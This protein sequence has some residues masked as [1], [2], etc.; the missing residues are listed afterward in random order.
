MPPAVAS[1]PPPAKI[2][3][4]NGTRQRARCA[5]G[6]QATS[7]S[8]FTRLGSP[9]ADTGASFGIGGN[10]SF[11]TSSSC[12][13]L[14]DRTL[15]ASLTAIRL[16]LERGNHVKVRC[17]SQ[18]TARRPFQPFPGAEC[19]GDHQAIAPGWRPAQHSHSSSHH[20]RINDRTSRRR[21]RRCCRTRSRAPSHPH[22]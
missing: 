15:S 13:S 22:G 14:R 16:D 21:K 8:A 2:A 5:S 9:S 17:F 12:Q 6:S 19:R 3:L 11:L 20:P 10:R 7:C 4:P 1:T 18:E